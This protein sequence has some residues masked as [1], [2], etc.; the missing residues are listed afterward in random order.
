MH[1]RPARLSLSALAWIA[2]GAAAFYT[3]HAQQLIDQRRAALRTFETT[4]R[5]A[6][7]ALDDT[8]AGQQAYL[9]PGQ[10]AA[11]WSPKV[12]TYR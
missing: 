11:D 4:A 7:D 8:Q 3:V 1:S 5:D 10:E 9:A 12:S 6:A 2:L